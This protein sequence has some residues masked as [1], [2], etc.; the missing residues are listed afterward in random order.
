MTCTIRDRNGAVNFSGYG[1]RE[2]NRNIARKIAAN[3]P[4]AIVT[5]GKVAAGNNAHRLSRT[6]VIR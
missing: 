5:F 2:E 3:T 1:W 6:R 4:T